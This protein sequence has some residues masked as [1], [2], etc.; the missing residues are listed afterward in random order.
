MRVVLQVT[1]SVPLDG[2]HSRGGVV[3]RSAARAG[4]DLS[5][6]LQRDCANA[7]GD[8]QTSIA[9]DTDRL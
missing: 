5:R 4:R 7:G 6:G 8:V 1:A 9:F 3:S 2:G